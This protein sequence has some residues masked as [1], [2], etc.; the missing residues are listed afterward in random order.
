[1]CRRCQGVQRNIL[2]CFGQTVRKI[3]LSKGISQ[4]KF[5][6]MCELHRTY[7]SDIELGKRNVSLENI[8]K[9][10]VALELKIS[11]LFEEVERNEAIS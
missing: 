1:M 11:Q 5:A 2:K 3:R 10:S 7:I 9:M 6:D 8:E 4:E